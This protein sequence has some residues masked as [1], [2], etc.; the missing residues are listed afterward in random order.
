MLMVA[1]VPLLLALSLG[2]GEHAPAG[3]TGYPWGSWQILAMFALSLLGLVAFVRIEQRATEPIVDLRLFSG[4]AFTLANAAAFTLGM[5]FLAAI[6]FLPLFMV[7]VVG[8]SATRSG[9]TTT[10]LTF[11]IVAANVLSGHLVAKL[12][13]YKPIMLAAVGL[14]V[15]AYLVMGLT[16]TPQSTQA[17]VTLKM[18]LVGLGLGPSIPLYTLAVQSAVPA[19]QLGVATSTATF[20]RQMGATIGI[21]IIGT[22]FAGSLATGM[23]QGMARATAGLPPEL[24]AQLPRGGLGQMGGAAEEAGPRM[25]FDAAEVKRTISEQFA[26]PPE[27]KERL[28]QAVERLGAELKLAFSAAIR[29]I[30]LVCAVIALVGLLLT[31]LLPEIP[32][33]RG[34]GAGPAATE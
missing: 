2:K 13:R 11:G 31:I 26:G 32:L 10:P 4:R 14:L 7:N 6:V 5:T 20:F 27:L 33:T 16:L 18:I 8:L 19:S 28:F 21:A 24:V 12:G 25:S 15:V 29:R 34:R 30:Y 22:V 23:G 17:E 1:I 9:L 3:A